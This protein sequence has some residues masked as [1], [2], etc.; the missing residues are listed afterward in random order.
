M[1]LFERARIKVLEMLWGV[2]WGEQGSSHACGNRVWSRR[3]VG[4]IEF[5]LTMRDTRQADQYS[6]EEI[7]EMLETVRREEARMCW[8]APDKLEQLARAV[9]EWVLSHGDIENHGHRRATGGGG[10]GACA[11]LHPFLEYFGLH[12]PKET[13]R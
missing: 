4:P 9:A 6:R 11:V 5:T 12:D 10:C 8:R 7:V 13:D 3:Y 2:A 1:N